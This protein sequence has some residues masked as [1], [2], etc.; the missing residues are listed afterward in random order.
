MRV[1]V[2]YEIS[3]TRHSG[4]IRIIKPYGSVYVQQNGFSDIDGGIP[5]ILKNLVYF[6]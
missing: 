4:F 3:D 2:R 1:N 6:F 5:T